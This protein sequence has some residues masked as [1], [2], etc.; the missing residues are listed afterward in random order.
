MKKLLM[1]SAALVLGTTFAAPLAQ[2]VPDDAI[3][4]LEVRDLKGALNRMG[5]FRP[6]LVKAIQ[7]AV[8][9][10]NAAA[11]KTEK[12]VL[13]FLGT[14]GV[15]SV[16]INKKTFQPAVLFVT[17]T[18]GSAVAKRMMDSTL[19]AD[20][21][22]GKVST[23]KEGKYS[24]N[25]TKDSAYGFQNNVAYLSTDPTTLRAF[26][27]KLSG[28]AGS[29]LS[30]SAA[31]KGVMGNVQNSNFKF[32]V[33]FNAAGDW[34]KAF[35]GS[36]PLINAAV[37]AVKTLGQWGGGASVTAQG[38]EST[39]VFF[40][41]KSTK[42]KA[43][44]SLLTYNKAD[45]NAATVVP[46]NVLSFSTSAADLPGFARYLDGWLNRVGDSNDPSVPA[47]LIPEL[48]LSKN[49]AWL[50]K[51]VAVV[52]LPS[53]STVKLNSPDPLESLTGTALVLE[54]Q[55]QTAASKG[56]QDLLSQLTQSSEAPIDQQSLTVNGST[57]TVLKDQDFS[58]YYTFKNNFML[59]AFSEADIKALTASGMRLSDSTPFKNAKYPKGAQSIEFS[60]KPPLQT[61]ESLRSTLELALATG[62]TDMKPKDQEKLVISLVNVMDN[63]Q[64]RTGG[65][66]GYTQFQ[67]GKIISKSVQFVNWK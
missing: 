9:A 47:E 56:M 17:S 65:S 26:L 57:V 45:L 51:E 33:N 42:D 63:M 21:K 48:A 61:R 24:F 1:T 8:G 31:Y 39:S 27:R 52:T 7:D 4:T 44:Y 15:I 38:M 20:K 53:A 43:L 22:A 5:A 54:V 60:A 35:A 32:Y 10:T 14:D 67:N 59:L 49:A 2:S 3:L 34:I 46:A 50:G 28:S 25:Q 13:E 41:N 55:S 29:S 36:D 66:Q 11:V 58:V 18:S 64:K 23:V 37:D 12:D 16:H 19:A 62:A 6:V 40:P 30:A